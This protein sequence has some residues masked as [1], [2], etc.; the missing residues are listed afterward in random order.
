MNATIRDKEISTFF[1][2]PCFKALMNSAPCP[3]VLQDEQGCILR[4]NKAFCEQF[5]FFHSSITGKNL[6]ALIVPESI[7]N[8]GRAIDES[9]IDGSLQQKETIRQKADGTELQVHLTAIP[10][11]HEGKLIARLAVYW[12]ITPLRIAE[13]KYKD[14]FT[15]SVEGIFQTSPQGRY[16]EANPAL[17]RI[18]GY[19]SPQ[20]L[21]NDLQD[22]GKQ[23]YVERDR[24]KTF[25]QHMQAKGKI[26]HFE[27]RIR[28]K[29]G[30]IIWISE[31]ARA[32]YDIKGRLDYFEGTVVDI[33]KRKYA[34]KM[35]RASEEEYRTIF[36]TTGNASI[37]I[38]Q[39]DTISLANSE[40][41]RL[42]GYDS[43]TIAKG[44]KLKEIVAPADR[45]RIQHTGTENG[46]YCLT[47]AAPHELRIQTHNGTIKDVVMTEAV[48]PGSL[49]RVVSL[50]DISE[51]KEA[52]LMLRHQAFHDPL[53]NLPNRFLLM[54]RLE[55]ALQ[56]AK[57]GTNHF[58]V[59]FLDLDRFK[60]I[61]DSL[62]HI[63]G[64]KLLG[65]MAQTVNAC[66][67]E[68]DTLARFGGDE[69]VILAEDL[70]DPPQPVR[71]AQRILTCLEQPFEVNGTTIYISTSIGIVLGSPQYIR[72]EQIIRDADTAM[73]RAKAQGKG[74]YAIFDEAMHI[75]A[76]RRLNMENDLRQGVEK[77]EF[78]LYYQPIVNMVNQSIIGFE[79]LIRWQHPTK[80]LVM[81]SDFIPVAEETGLIIPMGRFVLFEACRQMRTWML[82][83]PYHD[84]MII[85]VNVS[86][87]QLQQDTF[88]DEV[89]D[90]L[91]ETGLPAHCL[92]LEI[93][94]SMLMSLEDRAIAIFKKLKKMHVQIG[95]DDFGTGYSSLSY[96]HKFPVDTL[97]VD[98]SFV[99]AISENKENAKIVKTI[100]SLAHTLGL[101][102]VAEGIESSKHIKILEK[103]SCEYGQ[104]YY[105]SR[106][107]P[108]RQILKMLSM[109]EA[110]V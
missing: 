89:R 67:R 24:R 104:G 97:K 68:E 49:R 78:A 98:R 70:K 88:I 16:L 76:V 62:G 12:D 53:T 83:F 32:V 50:L 81:P 8:E 13:K 85:H 3:I 109:S 95:I 11:H 5:G 21:V 28:R 56:R 1:A 71:I 108:P 66:L 74:C 96:L 69:F 37:I 7:C 38:E 73:Y 45:N 44:L 46:S 10:V 61:N 77:K 2:Q 27:S 57:R 18:Y 64:D 94:E 31:H 58:A 23:L 87:V 26:S 65:K 34:E 4:A 25:L 84:E 35:L 14:I 20:A 9:I 110:V 86:G 90:C 93:T 79:A 100:I 72:A 101:N 51:R 29:D 36:E 15:N 55:H 33:T 39:D 99:T 30:T 75:N 22:I 102:V 6:N 42:T 82:H 106:P 54:D 80:G 48:L 52:E 105:F 91:H 60:L 103:M 59:L 107:Q 43:E 17:A 92:K 63:S 47:Q 19:D 40:F 41:I